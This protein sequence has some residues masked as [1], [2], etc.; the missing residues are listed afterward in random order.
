[1]L[2]LMQPHGLMISSILKHA[3]RH[4]GSTEVVSRTHENTTHRYTWA[5]VERRSRQLVRAMQAIGITPEDRIGTLAWNGYRH[6]EVYYAAP[7]MQAICHTINPRLHPDDITYIINHAGDKILFVD[8]SFAPLINAIAANIAGAV[9]TVVMLTDPDNM[10][11]VKL[12]AGIKL[13]CYD[14]MIDGA[15]E[16]YEWPLFDENTASAL[17]YTSGTTGRPKGVLYSHRSTYLHAM[18]AGLPDVMN[19]SAAD[20]VLPVVPM[21]HVNAWGIPYLAAMTGTALVL[22]GRHLD[23]PSMA[24]LLNTERVTVSAGVPTVWL[25]LLQHLRASGEALPTLKRLITGGSAAPPMLIEAFRDEYGVAVEHA[26]G[27]TEVSPLGT[28]N[29]PKPAQSGLTKDEAVTHMLKQGRVPPGI[30]MKIIDGN[31]QEL[32]WDGVAFG[33]LMVRGPWVASAYFGDEPGSA[34]DKD[35]WFATGDVATIDPDGFMEITDR[36][37][38]VIKSGG[39]WISSI[40]LENIA[41]SHPDVA[42]AAVI[43]ALHPKWDER[44]LLLVVPAP[45]KSVDPASVLAIYEGKVAKWWLPDEVVVVDE[46]PHTATGKLLKTSLR[47]KYKEHYLKA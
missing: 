37:K 30:D 4:H 9:K 10:P 1:M 36:S 18:A 16:D 35:G 21:F 44:P 20:R 27:M 19:V 22:P 32:P 11:E 12:A 26:W 23:G 25:G 3:A 17:C 46:L 31:G 45:G 47:T 29:A 8:S 39:E 28:Y 5:D 34:L 40:Q 41:V 24:N 13:I 43:A 38:D 42:E 7:G 2:G 6:L 14:Q 15:S 33:D